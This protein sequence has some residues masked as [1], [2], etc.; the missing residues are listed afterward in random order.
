MIRMEEKSNYNRLLI[1][2][3]LLKL[4]KEEL[5]KVLNPVLAQ[6]RYFETSHKVLC[7]MRLR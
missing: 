2:L 7:A 3:I 1:S 5:M 6:N 4:R